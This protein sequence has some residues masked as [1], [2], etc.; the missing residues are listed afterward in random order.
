MNTIYRSVDS[1]SVPLQGYREAEKS[2]AG[3]PNMI[4]KCA[5]PFIAFLAG[6]VFGYS[7]IF[8]AHTDV[9]ILDSKADLLNLRQESKSCP[10]CIHLEN[11]MC[12]NNVT[13]VG[14]QCATASCNMLPICPKTEEPTTDV[15]ADVPK[16]EETKPPPTMCTKEQEAHHFTC[17]AHE[18]SGERSCASE[19]T[20]SSA[21]C[22]PPPKCKKGFHL[23]G[24][25]P[26]WW[27]LCLEHNR[28]V[29]SV[30]K[31][32][33]CKKPNVSQGSST[34]MCAGLDS[35]PCAISDGYP[36]MFPETNHCP[37]KPCSDD[38]AALAGSCYQNDFNYFCADKGHGKCAMQ[39]CPVGTSFSEYP[40]NV[41]PSYVDCQPKYYPLDSVQCPSD[42]TCPKPMNLGS[43]GAPPVMKNP[44]VPRGINKYCDVMCMCG[45]KYEAGSDRYGPPRCTP[46]FNSHQSGQKQSSDDGKGIQEGCYCDQEANH[47]RGAIALDHTKFDDCGQFLPL[48]G[49]SVGGGQAAAYSAYAKSNGLVDVFPKP[50]PRCVPDE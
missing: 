44:K 16:V 39:K 34:C 33:T 2:P 3:S 7:D 48:Y 12:P 22:V 18:K 49:P 19:Y 40:K 23:Q 32:G 35:Q 43:Q 24:P 9:N 28:N 25:A 8:S 45:I 37:P 1:E 21:L 5:F 47:G 41:S 14:N 29:A 13:P 4:R 6:C 15:A 31:C 46:S 42:D 30:D 11:G 17:D 50:P 27:P 26:S 10:P 36:G 20:T 38:N